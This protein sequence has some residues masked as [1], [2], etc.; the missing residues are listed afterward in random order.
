MDIMKEVIFLLGGNL[1][2]K[3]QNF[4]QTTELIAENIGEISGQSSIYATDAWG[5]ES[6][7]IFWNQVLIIQT[8]LDP[9]DVLNAAQHV[10]Q[11]L[12]RVRSGEGYSSR[13]MDVDILFI[14]DMIINHERL[15]VPHPL[16]QERRFA[17]IPLVE[18]RRNMKHPVL[19]SSMQELL[20]QCPDKLEVKKVK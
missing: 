8:Q 16:L 15:I 4:K 6:E 18:V 2:D 20:D 12:G 10:E 1:G 7:D 13:T 3:A 11:L 5:F 9:I 14:D 19:N 17:L